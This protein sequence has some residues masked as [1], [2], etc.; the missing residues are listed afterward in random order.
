MKN[1]SSHNQH[2]T[3]QTLEATI[4]RGAVGG[5]SLG[6]CSRRSFLLAGSAALVAC[7]VKTEPTNPVITQTQYGPIKGKML[8]VETAQHGTQSVKMYRGIPYGAPVSGKNRFMAPQAPS[9]WSD[10]R[11]CYE[12]GA[13]APQARVSFARGQSPENSGKAAKY[14]PLVSTDQVVQSEDCLILNVWAPAGHQV[15]S[16]KKRAVMFWM[17]GGG[18]TSGSGSALWYDGRNLAAKQDVVVVTINHRLN[19]HGFC[20]LSAYGPQYAN[21]GNVG[22]LDCVKALE[23][24]RDNIENF[25]GDPDRVLIY[26]ESGG[27]RKTSMMMGFKPAQ[28]LYHRAIVQSGSMLRLETKEKAQKKAALLLKALNISPDNIEAIHDVSVDDLRAA[29]EPILAKHGQW[30]PVVG[31]AQLPAHPFSP[32]APEMSKHIPMIIGSNRTEMALF[33]GTNPIFD[34]LSAKGMVKM[35]AGSGLGK[36]A[37]ALAKN[38]QT[39]YPDKSMAE[40]FYMIMTD[41][42]YFLDGCIQAERK[43]DQAKAGGAPA[44][45]YHFERTTPVQ[46]GRFFSPHAQEIPFVFDQLAWAENMVGPKTASAQGLADQLSECWCNFA[47]TGVPSAKGMA[48]WPAYNRETRPT[49]LLDEPT[50][51]LANDPRGIERKLMMKLGSQQEQKPI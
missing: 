35:L 49:L 46:G 4:S 42:G 19:V 44:Y 5:L 36:A 13:S 9:A 20:D 15:D 12:Y 23:W 11:E 47:K 26:G 48:T 33:F 50:P 6:N 25:G 32:R 51:K 21:S 43:A 30:M 1:I 27:G 2:N 18:F 3:A 45:A 10:I 29:S 39:R 14:Q 40:L 41:R 24:V 37:P 17:H 31:G 38:Y 8:Q 7:S 28:G 16:S 34:T 22:M